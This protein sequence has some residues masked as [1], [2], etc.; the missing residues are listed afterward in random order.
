[1]LSLDDADVI[2]R[3]RLRRARLDGHD[4]PPWR[5]LL[6]AE[7]IVFKLFGDS[8]KIRD[9]AT[10]G[11]VQGQPRIYVHEGLV[12]RE[13]AFAACHELGHVVRRAEGLALGCDEERWCNRFAAACLLP[14]DSLRRAWRA[15]R[16]DWHHLAAAR[17]QVA[18]SSLE[19]R[20]D[21]LQL[22][23]AWLFEGDRL[24]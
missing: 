18:E 8:A 22:A 17:P 5:E 7:G 16:D 2:A 1:M 9:L 24:R 23:S 4:A 20:I 14:E 13:R 6:E 21:E 12:G 11:W 19:L 10:H 3:S 15:H